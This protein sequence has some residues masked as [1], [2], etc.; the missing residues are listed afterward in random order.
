MHNT[1]TCRLKLSS[2]VQLWLEN[3]QWAWSRIDI[4]SPVSF[5]GNSPSRFSCEKAYTACTHPCLSTRPDTLRIF[6]WTRLLVT[7][8]ANATATAAARP[9]PLS[10]DVNAPGSC[11][12]MWYQSNSASEMSGSLRII[13]SIYPRTGYMRSSF[14]KIE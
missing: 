14:S 6:L 7:N 2:I 3:Y 13:K 9:F 11:D 12:V 10:R 4:H 1:L 8:A 5:S